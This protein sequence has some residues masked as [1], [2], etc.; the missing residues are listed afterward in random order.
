MCQC[1]L[2]V[3]IRIVVTASGPAETTL[4]IPLGKYRYLE[5]R[6][7]DVLAARQ[8][9]GVIH[10]GA[11]GKGEMFTVFFRGLRSPSHL[12]LSARSARKWLKFNIFWILWPLMLRHSSRIIS[13]FIGGFHL[14]MSEPPIYHHRGSIGLLGLKLW[15]KTR[16]HT[17]D[18][19]G[20]P[21]FTS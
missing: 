14:Q 5:T 21:N 8:T 19:R 15:L 1:L 3:M 6:M 13:Q 12:L 10:L 4:E 16:S 7:D 18:L 11:L 20:D 9:N 17:L 2:G